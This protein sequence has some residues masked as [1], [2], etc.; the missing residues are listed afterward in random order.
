MFDWLNGLTQNWHH[1][2]PLATL[3]TKE[4]VPEN[5]PA[6]TRLIEQAIVGIVAAGISSY[7]TLQVD[8]SQIEDMKSSSLRAQANTSIAIQ[9]SEQRVTAQITELRAFIMIRKMRDA[10]EDR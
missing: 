6:T 3:F 9:Q 7:V 1:Y 8:H 4:N 2:V 10:K 5:R